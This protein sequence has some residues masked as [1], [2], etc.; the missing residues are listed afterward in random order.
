MDGVS[1]KISIN[2]S[3]RQ[4]INDELLAIVT[5]ALNSS[6][7][8]PRNIILEITESAVTHERDKAGQV[9]QALKALGLQLAIDDFGTGYASL[10]NLKALPVDHVKIDQSFIRDLV[11]DPGDAAITRGVIA[12]AHGMQLSVLAEGVENEAQLDF[13]RAC[14]CDE[15]QGYYLAHAM[16]AEDLVRWVNDRKAQAAAAP[17][18]QRSDDNIPAPLRLH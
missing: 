13:L 1:L 16:P 8:D 15:V 11:T 12:M 3:A 14:H 9:L 17:S 2:V 5:A 7:A 6:G 4:L 10:A 18:E